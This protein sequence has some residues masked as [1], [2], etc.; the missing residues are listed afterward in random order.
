MRER[1]FKVLQ[2]Q[3]YD[4]IKERIL[5]GTL[6]YNQIYSESKLALEIGISRTPVRDAVHRLY[7]EDLIDIIPNK[8]FTLHKMTRQDV[9][10]T[11]GVRSA[12]E[13]Y[14]SRLAA[15]ESPSEARDKLLSDL[16]ASL[17]RQEELFDGSRDVEAFAEEDQNFHYL[18]VSHCGNQALT[19]TFSHYMY[20]I[21]KLACYSLGKDG[22]MESTLREHRQILDQ[23]SAGNGQGAYDATLFHMEAPLD[24]NLESVYESAPG[25]AGG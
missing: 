8:G 11:Y 5:N 10:E 22:R 18:L 2:T 15:L 12:I 6:E 21:K 1:E 17:K 9:I 13:G 14:C 24:I 19:E 7:Q 3:A 20:K 16:Y 4:Y 25:Q 23:I